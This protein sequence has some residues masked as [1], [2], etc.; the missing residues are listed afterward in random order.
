MWGGRV[1]GERTRSG[2][3]GGRINRAGEPVIEAKEDLCLDRRLVFADQDE[4]FFTTGPDGAGF[5]A[6]GLLDPVDQ[7]RGG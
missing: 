3:G 6:D 5:L 4:R 7:A 2:W 1:G